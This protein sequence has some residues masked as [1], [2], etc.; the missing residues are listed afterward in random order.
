MPGK[1][2]DKGAAGLE[3]TA[4]LSL[5]MEGFAE[6]PLVQRGPCEQAGQRVC[7]R[8]RLRLIHKGLGLGRQGE[9][10]PVIVTAALLMRGHLRRVA[11]TMPRL[12]QHEGGDT[13]PQDEGRGKNPAHQ[14][15]TNGPGRRSPAVT[16][17]R[18]AA[19]L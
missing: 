10:R 18:L 12:G 9:V 3:M 6:R 8:I 2:L 19:V 5:E 1:A 15:D 13:A 11:R 16:A 14:T 17:R 7:R 4:L